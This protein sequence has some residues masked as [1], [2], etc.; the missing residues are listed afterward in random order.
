[1][2]EN[3]FDWPNWPAAQPSAHCPLKARHFPLQRRVHQGIFS[4]EAID[5]TAFAY[6]RTLCNS[7]EREALAAGFKNDSLGGI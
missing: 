1:M 2:G 6:T 3:Q 7:V 4:R 5:E